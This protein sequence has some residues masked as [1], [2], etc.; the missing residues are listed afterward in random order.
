M[1]YWKNNDQKKFKKENEMSKL[2]VYFDSE[3][4]E[5]DAITSFVEGDSPFAE[6]TFDG[7]IEMIEDD[8]ENPTK[9]GTVFIFEIVD[10]GKIQTSHKFVSNKK[11]V[12]K[13]SA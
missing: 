2:Y 11:V 7:L 10:K 5:E 12:D 8:G 1:A 6:K 13:K 3:V 9:D 4:S